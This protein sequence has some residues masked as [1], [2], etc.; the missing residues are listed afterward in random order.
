M[1][2]DTIV[3]RA[4]AAGSSERAVIRISGP[5]ARAV[6]ALVF[7]P[8][9][10]PRR[11]VVDGHV[12]VRGRAVAAFAL[13]M[14]APRSFTGEDTVELHVPG[15]ALLVQLLLD[16][17]LHDGNANGVRAA[18]PGEFTA[19]AVQNG[20]LDA[21][22]TEGLLMLLHAHDR[23]AAEQA[24]VWLAGDAGTA[25]ARLRARLQDALALLEV[26]LDFSDGDTGEVPAAI[27]RSQ[28]ED[29][30]HELAALLGGLPAAAPGGE[31]LL[32]GR[33]NAGKSSLANALAGR[34]M[35]LVD[36]HAGTT[37]DLLR[38]ELPD[39]GVLWDA[40]GDLDA[41]DAVDAAALALRQQLGGGAGGLV[42]VLDANAPDVPASASTMALP[43]AA[44]VWTKCDLHAPPPLPAVI[45][46]RA[47]GVP[48]FATSA[49]TGTGLTELRA[50]LATN[51]RAGVVDAGGPL[52]LALGAAAIAV[53]HALATVAAG[54]E[55]V[56][57]EVQA[58]LAAL[59]GL[60]GS[61]SPE[62]LLDRI[63]ARFC[64]GK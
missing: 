41:P 53:E 58:A 38:V 18:L 57:V 55:V 31:L 63:Y 1:L 45:A 46:A 50:W 19:R 29:V 30:H 34:T 54:P 20:R 27:W 47:E 15:S 59:D 4:T 40:P 3:A 21:A 8:E 51:A 36:D 23:R 48:V 12:T 16:A 39:G 11:A 35:A 14:V 61:H 42:L 37:R 9:L 49:I 56:A 64:L 28:L 6:A 60:A 62:Q 44:I 2:G 26:G 24:V 52:R 22:A 43:R 25:V 32:H 33:A 5:R 10:S 7:A 17:M 13:V